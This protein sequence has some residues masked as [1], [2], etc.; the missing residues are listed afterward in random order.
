MDIKHKVI[1]DFERLHVSETGSSGTMEKEGLS[2]ILKRFKNADITVATLATD[3]SPQ[4]K[5]MM[6]NKD[7]EEV[8]HQFDVW[9]FNKS[10]V[11]K[12]HKACKEKEMEQLRRWIPAISNHLWWAAA[13]CQNDAVLLKEKW[14]SDLLHTSNVHTWTSVTKFMKCANDDLDPTDDKEWL[15]PGDPQHETLHKIVTNG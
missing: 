13:T 5:A 1:L 15:V 9:H 3:R 6:R 11:K 4:I 2:R 8:D 7:F 12:L 14:I 10:V